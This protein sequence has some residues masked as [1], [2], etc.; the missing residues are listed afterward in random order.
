[1]GVFAS[2]PRAGRPEA[3]NAQNRIFVEEIAR[4]TK[5]RAHEG[6]ETRS[7]TFV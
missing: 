2:A 5:Q 4:W 7:V 3:L 6:G 1:L